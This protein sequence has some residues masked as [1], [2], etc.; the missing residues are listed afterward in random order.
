MGYGSREDPSAGAR[1]RG[2]ECPKI[3]VVENTTWYNFKQIG[4]LLLHSDILEF[5]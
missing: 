5:S 2:A 3:L 1:I 4:L